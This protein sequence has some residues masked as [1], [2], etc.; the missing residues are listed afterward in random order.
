MSIGGF[1][2][3]IYDPAYEGHCFL[4]GSIDEVRIISAAQ[5]PD[6]LRLCYMNQRPDDKLVN[7]K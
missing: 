2:E 6:R 3:G 4:K 7:F 5:S 1:L